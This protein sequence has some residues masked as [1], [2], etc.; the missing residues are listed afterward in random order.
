MSFE[1]CA[2]YLKRVWDMEIRERSDGYQVVQH[3]GNGREMIVDDGLDLD[4][5]N[6]LC[7]ELRKG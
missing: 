3:C 1:R 5:V 6:Q 2:R 7:R 4:G